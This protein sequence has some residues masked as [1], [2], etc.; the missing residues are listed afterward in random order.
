MNV[1][2]LGRQGDAAE[3][4][5]LLIAPPGKSLVVVDMAAIEARVNAFFSGEQALVGAFREGRDVYCEFGSI[6]YGVKVRKPLPSD[7]APVASLM[8]ARRQFSKICVLG[9][10]FGMGKDRFA[11]F[12]KCDAPTAERAVKVYRDRYTAITGFWKAIERA[13]VYTAKYHRPCALDRG[14]SFHSTDDIDVVITLP[15]GR[16]LNYHRVKLEAGQ[17]GDQASVYNEVEHKHDPLWGGVL[18]ENTVQATSRDVL[19]EAMLRLEDLGHHTALHVHD[20][21]VIACP[22]DQAPEV[23]ATA[24]RELSRSPAWAPGLPLSAEGVIGDM[25]GLH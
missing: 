13:F 5:G 17:Y 12:A 15:N 7:P 3:L 16:R 18:T 9:M 20:E 8:K 4:R 21:L 10:G 23:L 2:N 14:L 25:Y 24:I 22:R 1:Q 6:F 11:D 19:T